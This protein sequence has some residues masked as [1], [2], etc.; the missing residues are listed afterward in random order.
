MREEVLTSNELRHALTLV[1]HKTRLRYDD[2]LRG[3]FEPVYVL[4]IV[5][6][7]DKTVAT[8]PRWKQQST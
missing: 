8:E 2:W 3:T 1:G 7:G 4:L 5:P 6:W